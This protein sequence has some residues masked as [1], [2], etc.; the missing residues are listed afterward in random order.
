MRIIVYGGDFATKAPALSNLLNEDF[1]MGDEDFLLVF[2]ISNI[3]WK[4]LVE[5]YF[6]HGLWK[7]KNSEIKNEQTFFFDENKIIKTKHHH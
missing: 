7:S 4:D 5:G 3:K 1:Q 6:K 2:K